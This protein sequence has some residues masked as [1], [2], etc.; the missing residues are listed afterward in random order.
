MF[1]LFYIYF[2]IRIPVS[3]SE[4]TYCSAFYTS[5]DWLSYLHLL[6]L[7]I[8][9]NSIVR[10]YSDIVP[11]EGYQA[12]QLIT[13]ITHLLLHPRDLHFL[14]IFRSTITQLHKYTNCIYLLAQLCFTSFDWLF[15]RDRCL[16][17]LTCTLLTIRITRELEAHDLTAI[18]SYLISP[19]TSF[20]NER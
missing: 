9:F 20:V 6:S 5:F 3:A 4:P 18:W 19:G 8:K 12:I 17:L 15:L 14:H 7:I 10:L 1:L 11:S 2:C 13:N 16:V